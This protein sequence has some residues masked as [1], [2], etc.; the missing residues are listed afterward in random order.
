MNKNSALVFGHGPRS[1]VARLAKRTSP[2][3]SKPPT[4][5]DS[6]VSRVLAAFISVTVFYVGQPRSPSRVY[7]R[8]KQA[9][10]RPPSFP[11]PFGPPPLSTSFIEFIARLLA[12][13]GFVLPL[14]DPPLSLS[15]SLFVR[16]TTLDKF[17]FFFLFLFL[18]FFYDAR[19]ART[20]LLARSTSRL[21]FTA[22]FFHSLS[23]LFDDLRYL[24]PYKNV[25]LLARNFIP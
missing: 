24:R 2:I 11:S 15:L 9:S 22:S 18:F 12:R 3:D 13:G 10:K 23:A 6:P 1:V 7:T 16:A 4:R 21:V 5:R 17:F 25:R 14:H 8:S 19:Y 20:V